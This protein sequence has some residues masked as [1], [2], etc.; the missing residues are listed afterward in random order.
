MKCIEDEEFN[1]VDKINACKYLLSLDKEIALQCFYKLFSKEDYIRKDL[2]YAVGNY[3]FNKEHYELSKLYYKL[4]INCEEPNE[5][6][7]FLY[8]QNCHINSLLQ[9]GLIEY[10]KGNID[11]FTKYNKDILEIDKDN[12]TAKYNLSL[13]NE[14]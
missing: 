2:F 4:C 11:L 10:N 13:L 9:L 6:L 1:Q 5:E 8:D 14:G 3:F 12:E 7:I